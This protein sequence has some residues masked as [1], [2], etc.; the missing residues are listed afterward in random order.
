MRR[1]MRILLGVG[2]AVLAGAG[3]CGANAAD[4][5]VPPPQVQG[6][7]PV[8]GPPPAEESY[9]YPP[10]PPVYEARPP[11]AYYTYAPPPPVAVYPGPYYAPAPYWRGYG[12]YGGYG[13]HYAYGYG[14]HYA[15]G[16]G[17]WGRGYRR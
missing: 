1:S 12:P 6:P 8:Y 9:A 2:A 14:S 11:V 5:P 16:Y 7:P 10:P 15:G 4:I 13:P 17:H 3:V